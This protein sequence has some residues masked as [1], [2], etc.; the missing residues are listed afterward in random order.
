MR[1]RTNRAHALCSLC[2]LKRGNH[3]G[4][5]M[6]NLRIYGIARTRAFRALWIAKELG[7][8]YEAHPDRDRRAGARS[9]TTSR[10]TPT[11]AC[12]D[13]RRRLRPVGNRSRSRS[14][15]PRSTAGSIPRRSKA[16]PRPGNGA[17]WSVQESTA[18]SNIWS[19]HAVRL[20]PEDRD[21]QRLAEA[22]RWWKG[23]SRCSMARFAGARI[24]SAT[25]SPSPT[26]TSLR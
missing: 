5:S 19:L 7:L 23:R 3:G 4:T 20:P 2:R 6:S 18:A 16:R 11:A 12:G 26:S 15:S 22:L 1:A 13:R 17:C 14:I 25:T 24:C 8:D 10:S 21:P 9:R